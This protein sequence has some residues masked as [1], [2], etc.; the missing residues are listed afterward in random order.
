[1]TQQK[2][3]FINR[4]VELELLDNLYGSKQSE[5]DDI[6]ERRK[7]LSCWNF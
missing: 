6:F 4:K 7:S 3:K 5:L 2:L 1:M